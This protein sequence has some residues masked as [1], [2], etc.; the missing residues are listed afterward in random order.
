MV[1][2]DYFREVVGVGEVWLWGIGFIE[3]YVGKKYFIK[4]LGDASGGFL[5]FSGLRSLNNKVVGERSPSYFLKQ[6]VTSSSSGMK[7]S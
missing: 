5:P 7:R 3:A 4:R 6:P 2:V 1:D